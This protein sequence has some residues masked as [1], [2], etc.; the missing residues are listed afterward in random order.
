MDSPGGDGQRLYRR[1]GNTPGRQQRRFHL[2]YASL[3]EES[4]QLREQLR[5]TLQGC[6]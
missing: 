2:Q 1:I 4:A 5:P 3:R 6:E